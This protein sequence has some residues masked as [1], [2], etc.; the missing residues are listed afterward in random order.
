MQNTPKANVFKLI[1]KFLSSPPL[2]IWGSGATVAYGL[3]TMGKLNEDIGNKIPEF[4]KKNDNL[5]VELS[6]D[7]YNEVMPN[8][9]EVIWSSINDANS[10]A[11]DTLVNDS[12]HLFEPIKLMIDKFKRA[13]PQIINIVTTN[14][15]CILENVMSFY[16]F[17]FT[18]GFNGR[19]FCRFDIEYF[20]DKKMINLVKVH[21]SLKWFFINGEIRYLT[22]SLQNVTSAIIAPSKKKYQ[23]CFQTPY[24]ELIQKSDELINKASVFLVIGFGFNDE[25][26]TPKIK[27][28]VNQGIPI[29]LITKSVTASTIAELKG[30][31]KYILLEEDTNCSSKTKITYKENDESESIVLL[32]DE[33]YWSLKNFISEVL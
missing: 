30:A 9:K 22:N 21:G 16:G 26:L 20:K 33:N 11:M 28:K 19:E 3:P 24:R 2:I 17:T 23:E 31:K 25:H 13:H 32:L 15:D 10:L 12:N 29:V 18:D 8:I 6:N 7:K 27:E 14:Y 4:N 1:Q 5:E